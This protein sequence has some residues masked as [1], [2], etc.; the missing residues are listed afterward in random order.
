MTVT[1]GSTWRTRAR[2]RQTVE[3]VRWT[4]DFDPGP[5]DIGARVVEVKLK[6]QPSREFTVHG[7]A[8]CGVILCAESG[9]PSPMCAAAFL[10]EDFGKTLVAV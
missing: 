9:V 4:D 1:F 10:P 8:T 6:A 5:Q 2:P 7:F 3:V